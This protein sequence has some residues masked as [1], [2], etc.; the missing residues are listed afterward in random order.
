[1]NIKKSE[2]I[3]KRRIFDFEREYTNKTVLLIGGADQQVLPM[4][5]AYNNMGCIVDVLCNSKLDIGYVSRFTH[6][7]I[8]GVCDE[9][10]PKE[11]YLS[12]KDTLSQ[13]KYDAVIPMNDFVAEIL[14]Q[15]KQELSENAFISVNSW[16]IFSLAIDKL[17]TMQ[18][19]MDNGIPCPKT[20]CLENTSEFDDEGLKYPLVV[21]PRVSYGARGF[22]VV[23]DRR[24]LESVLSE[25]SKKYGA[26]LIQEYIPQTSSQYQVEMFMS[27]GECVSIVIMDKLR[28]YPL[29][30]GS[31]TINVTVKDSDIENT[32]INLLKKMGWEGYASL[33]LIRD[34]RDGVAKVLEINPRLNGTAKI[35]FA[36]GV[37]IAKQFMQEALGDDVTPQLDYA[38]GIYLRYFHKDILWFIK[39]KDRFKTNPS[40]FSWKNTVDEIF[41]INDIFP[42]FTYSITSLVKL[43]TMGG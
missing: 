42:I 43:F 40:W 8:L 21:K 17:K 6:N 41:D 4:I 26:M 1:M 5:R 3:N 11:T 16:D 14:S 32:C 18:I 31:S 7:K 38:E 28:W 15:N 2:K 25:T 29:K 36:A 27:A 30:G 19:C 12:I 35:C 24:T 33:D 9:A 37:N 23:A 20:Y 39:S 10:K 34:P 22:N 13:K